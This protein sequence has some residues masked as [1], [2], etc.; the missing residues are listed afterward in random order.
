MILPFWENPYLSSAVKRNLQLS[1]ALVQAMFNS[2][3][4]GP[5]GI[6][7]ILS[8]PVARVCATACGI[9][10]N[11]FVGLDSIFFPIG[12]FA[13]LRPSSARR[14]FVLGHGIIYPGAFDP[15]FQPLWLE[16]AIL[17]T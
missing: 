12:G 16:M 15:N 8:R 17:V 6:V 14:Q 1:R 11:S 2:L 3:N 10:G 7:L 9:F 4:A 5:E 13:K